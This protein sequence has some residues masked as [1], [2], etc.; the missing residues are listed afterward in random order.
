MKTLLI[1]TWC[2]LA[3]SVTIITLF[4]HLPGRFWIL[5]VCDFPRAQ[6]L[7]VGILLIA[8][9]FAAVFTGFPLKPAT[10]VLFWIFTVIISVTVL[11]QALWAV[12]FTPLRTV[13]VPKSQIAPGSH[14]EQKSALRLITANVD[15][16]NEDPPRAMDI[17]IGESPDILALVETDALWDELIEAHRSEYPHIVKELREKGRGVAVLSRIPIEASEI[18]YLVDKDRPSIWLQFC[19]PDYE[20]VRL[21]ITH[22]APPGLP[23][24]DGEGR[25]SSKKRDIELDLIA[26]HIGDRQ[27]QHWILAGDF[28]DVGWSWTTMQA[29]EVSGLLD[30]RIGRGMFNTFPASYPFL[31]YPI[32]HVLV[33]DT[34]KLIDIRRIE[35]I[36]SDHLPLLADLELPKRTIP[37]T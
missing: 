5:R 14:R 27:N 9:L 32:D 12:Q 23:K 1:T 29:K 25:H 30:P 19:I 21:I 16:E 20:C 6:V 36:G 15:F 7:G 28:N 34:F 8:V 24:R 3:M 22:P 37:P 35:N 11:M 4:S 10:G 13:T 31:R 26:S 17:L 18:K 2:L 33:S